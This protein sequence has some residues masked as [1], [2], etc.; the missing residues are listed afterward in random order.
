[1][2]TLKLLLSC[3]T[4][5]FLAGCGEPD[6]RSKAEAG[7]PN[8]Q[9]NLGV[10][11]Y[12]GE[13]VPK[14]SA[15]ALKWF[16]KAAD[17]GHAP[18]QLHLAHMYAKGEGVPKDE[19]EAYAWYNLAAE[20]HDDARKRRDELEKTLT[21]EQKARAQQRSTELYKEIEEEIEARKK[22]GGK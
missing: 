1:M 18:A 21:P 9:S 2:R 5:V 8:A 4:V 7:D 14:D 13:G 10:M 3:L 12:S 11:Y 16:R 6:I 17:Q 20:S 15:E 22:A 19:A